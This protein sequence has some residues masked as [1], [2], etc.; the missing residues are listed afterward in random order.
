MEILTKD[1]A[2]LTE[3]HPFRAH[4]PVYDHEEEDSL[5]LIR[6]IRD[7][8]IRM[9]IL[10]DRQDRIVDGRRRR[11]SARRL[12]L[13]GVPCLVI[14]DGDIAGAIISGLVMRL[15]FTRSAIAYLA[16]PLIEKALEESRLRRIEN[17]RKGQQSPDS[18]LS[19]LSGNDAEQ[20]AEQNGFGRRFL[21]E[22]KA[23]H[24]LFAKDR[25]YKELM[26]PRILRHC[27]GGE[28]E[29]KRPVG[30]GAVISGYD[31]FKKR[32]GERQDNPQLELAFRN[33]GGTL[34]LFT[35]WAGLDKADRAE[36]LKFIREKMD[37]MEP[38]QCE[39]SAELASQIAAELHRRAKGE[40]A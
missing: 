29:D 27:V 16:Y 19:A 18:A 22:A 40:A 34:S 13:T 6:D 10:I 24:K 25:A 39:Q 33:V 8:G 26:E 5:A 32:G 14:A 9:P 30:L 7:H 1:P 28:H 11:D 31:G 17:M 23:V 35:R 21:F 12:G 4:L 36:L 15:H 3:N 38:D 2:T 37:A 20:L